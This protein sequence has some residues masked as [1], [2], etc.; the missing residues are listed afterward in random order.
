MAMGWD[1][2]SGIRERLALLAQ[3]GTDFEPSLWGYHPSRDVWYYC[4]PAKD[5]AS[6]G[7]D[8]KVRQEGVASLAL[9]LKRWNMDRATAMAFIGYPEGN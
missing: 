3:W 5:L 8:L 4:G 9:I 7:K 6:W 2:Q 1:H